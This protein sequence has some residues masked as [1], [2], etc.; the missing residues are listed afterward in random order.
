MSTESHRGALTALAGLLALGL[1]GAIA[2]S[3][4]AD[5]AL[6]DL[7]VLA[8]C[9]AEETL[10]PDEELEPHERIGIVAVA[11]RRPGEGYSDASIRLAR[12]CRCRLT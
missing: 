6:V 2:S 4:V 10:C 9:D 8:Q 3:V 7:G 5:A 12:D 11:R 1:P